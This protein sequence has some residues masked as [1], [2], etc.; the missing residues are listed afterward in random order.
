MGI[1]KLAIY[2]FADWPRDGIVPTPV[3]PVAIGTIHA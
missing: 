2:H 1:Y 3:K